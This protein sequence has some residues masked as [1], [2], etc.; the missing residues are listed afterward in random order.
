MWLL[1]SQG[2]AGVQ[3]TLKALQPAQQEEFM[4]A[5]KNA[6]SKRSGST[7]E[8]EVWEGLKAY[9]GLDLLDTL[10]PVQYTEFAHFLLRE[11]LRGAFVRTA[12]A[13]LLD[14]QRRG[15]VRAC[16]QGSARG[17]VGRDICRPTV[18]ARGALAAS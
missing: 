16:V 13:F 12:S 15:V 17:G 4:K 3:A 2:E 18:R 10:G 5:L 11:L 1:R 14:L 9:A 6:L 7:R 8:Q